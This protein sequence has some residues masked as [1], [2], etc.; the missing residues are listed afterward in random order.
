MREGCD[1]HRPSA[2]RDRA[3][4]LLLA[5]YGMR[6]GKVR[7]LRLDDIGWEAGIIRLR[8]PKTGSN[9]TYPLTRT[10]GEAIV[11]YLRE[12][13]PRS[14]AREV[15]L[16][17]RAPVQPLG[18]SLMPVMVGTRMRAADIKCE[19]RSAHSLRHACAQR[20]LEEGLSMQEIG[21]CLGHRSPQ[22][23]GRYAKV[24]LA[25]LREVADFDLEG[26]A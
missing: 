24:A 7:G 15:F 1:H 21:D 4:L 23:T 11:R 12:A 22:S 25:R 13:R 26:L 6:A 10:V 17:L 3:I 9:G 5:V 2:L 20:L 16:T 18:A 8:R 14:T 19:R